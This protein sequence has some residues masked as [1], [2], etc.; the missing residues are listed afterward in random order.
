[1]I[2]SI[3]LPETTKTRRIISRRIL[4]LTLQ[5]DT[6]YAAQVYATTAKTFVEK[7]TQGPNTNEGIQKLIATSKFDRINI[8]IHQ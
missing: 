5:E 8:A 1:M 6:F 4:G 7:V 2:K 3:F